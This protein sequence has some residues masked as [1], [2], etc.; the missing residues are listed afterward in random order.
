MPTDE[1]ILTW[2]G[3]LVGSTALV[4]TDLSLIYRVAGFNA[5]Y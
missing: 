3:E 2:P 5:S 4:A 1:K